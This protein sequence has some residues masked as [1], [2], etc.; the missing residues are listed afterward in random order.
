ME[1]TSPQMAELT[2][3]IRHHPDAGV[4]VKAVALRALGLGYQQSEA[5][6]LVAATRQ[7]V[8][9][10]A[11]RYQEGGLEAL[12][13]AA[14]R[15]R[16]R[17]AVDAEVME[18]ARQSPRQFGI[19]RSRWTLELLAQAVPSLQGFSPSGVLR[20]LRR[21]GLSYKRGQAWLT[22]PDPNYEKKTE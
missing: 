18:Y 3:A 5:A 2:Q 4:R 10:W 16:H 19:D 15:G 7:S 22:S 13:V 12:M 1:W 9:E 17:T 20:V 6:C 14:G 8:A 11:K 21:C